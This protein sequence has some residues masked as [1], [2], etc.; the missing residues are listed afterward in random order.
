[1]TALAVELDHARL[2]AVEPAEQMQ[3]RRL[4]GARAAE[5]AT[6]SPAATSR[7]ALVE[8]AARGPAL[9]ERLDQ[10]ARADRRHPLKVRTRAGPPPYESM[11]VAPAAPCH[12]RRAPE[13]SVGGDER[14]PARLAARRRRRAHDRRGGR[15]ATSS[16]PATRRASPPTAR[17]RS[18]WRRER[19]PDLVVLDLMLPGLDGLE[20]MRRLRALGDAAARASRSSC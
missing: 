12:P 14:P 11:N 13:Q 16:A 18:S 10:P 4:A 6:T 17:R 3:Q 5:H 8:H 9:A 1:M 2:R 19:A 15:R 7:S 20:V